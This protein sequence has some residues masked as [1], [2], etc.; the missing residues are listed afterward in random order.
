[1]EGSNYG[2][3]KDSGG[4]QQAAQPAGQKKQLTTAVHE[5]GCEVVNCFCENETV[6]SLLA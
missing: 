6:W 4:V 2:K 5:G 3:R 1:M